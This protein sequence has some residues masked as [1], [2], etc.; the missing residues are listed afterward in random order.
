MTPVGFDCLTV[1]AHL[2]ICA[3]LP[4]RLFAT[5]HAQALAKLKQAEQQA[6]IK[7]KEDANIDLTKQIQNLEK[8]RY[9]YEF[10]IKE[11]QKEIRPWGGTPTHKHARLLLC[12]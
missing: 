4:A 5:R 10:K 8:Y 9:V 7:E 12:L 6:I 3:R 2:C 11:L 1:R